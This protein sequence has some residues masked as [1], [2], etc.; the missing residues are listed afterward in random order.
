MDVS[1]VHRLADTLRNIIFKCVLVLRSP[2]FGCS[3]YHH[4]AQIRNFASYE[5]YPRD[6]RDRPT[7][8]ASTCNFT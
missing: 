8:H 5:S 7:W 2:L 3:Y 6:R 4:I 1:I